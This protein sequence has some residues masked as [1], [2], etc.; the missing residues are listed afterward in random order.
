M[1]NE[2]NVRT[3]LMVAVVAVSIP[4]LFGVRA[5]VD[6]ATLL[7]AAQESTSMSDRAKFVGT[8][9]LITTEI[10]DGNTGEWSETPNFNRI[11]YITY[12]DTGHMGVHIMPRSRLPFSSFPPPGAEVQ[13]ALQGYTAY[14][15]SF[16]V[17]EQQ[18]F[19]E[20]QRFGHIN[21]G[22]IVDV[23]RFYDFEGVGELA[24]IAVE[25]GKAV[26]G[27]LKMGISG[28]QAGDPALVR[29]CHQIGLDYVSCSP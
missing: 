20:H 23:K 15:G 28:E 26:R 12:A 22:G 6:Q 18:Q 10:K 8:Y 2:R 27:N 3:V 9:R 25:R 24:R 5:V 14:F 19:V 17:D 11:G 4:I 21:Q 16:T 1:R 13:V 7:E 29:F